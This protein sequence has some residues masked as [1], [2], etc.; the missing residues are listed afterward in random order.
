[1]RYRKDDLTRIR[2]RYKIVDD[3]WVWQHGT[4]QQGYPMVRL[5]DGTMVLVARYLKQLEYA[6]QF[7]KDHRVKKTCDCDKCVNPAHYDVYVRGDLA[8]SNGYKNYGYDFN[9]IKEIY[10]DYMSTPMYWGKIADYSR[11]YGV[12]KGTLQKVFQ[13]GKYL[14]QELT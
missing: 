1:M 7:T 3:H 12:G 14:G 5:N 9:K 13:T 10:A 2:E 8:W 4:H 6:D 11:H